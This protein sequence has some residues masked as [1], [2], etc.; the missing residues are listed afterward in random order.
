[1]KNAAVVRDIMDAQPVVLGVEMPIATALDTLLDNH[2]IS[3]PV[4]DCVSIKSSYTQP[5]AWASLL[6]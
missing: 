3:A 1:M 4:V 2:I 5:L 6:A